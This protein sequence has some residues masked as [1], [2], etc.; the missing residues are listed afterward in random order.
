VNFDEFSGPVTAKWFNPARDTE[1]VVHGAD[2]P[3]RGSQKFR[4]PGD[5]GTG[6]N[7][8]VLLLESR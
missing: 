2:L 5:N 3:N 8:W 6:I 4:M 1:L 7:D